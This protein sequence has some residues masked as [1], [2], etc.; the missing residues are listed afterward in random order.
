MSMYAVPNLFLTSFF[1][2]FFFFVWFISVNLCHF[3]SA[4]LDTSID[5]WQFLMF[6]LTLIIFRKE[7]KSFV[8]LMSM[9][10][11]FVLKVPLKRC[12]LVPTCCNFE[13]ITEKKSLNIITYQASREARFFPHSIIKVFNFLVYHLFPFQKLYRLKKN[14]IKN[15][16]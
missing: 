10:I 9:G 14:E 13:Y 15:C 6:G 16:P 4:R 7:K 2:I 11:P 3:I 5:F 8:E 12:H 1:P